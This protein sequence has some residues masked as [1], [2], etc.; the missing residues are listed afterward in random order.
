MS[1]DE[2][3]SQEGLKSPCERMVVH[4]YLLDEKHSMDAFV[5]NKAEAEMLGLIRHILAQLKLDVKV[6]SF[7]RKEGGL[8]DTFMLIVNSPALLVAASV[9][10]A[11]FLTSIINIIVSLVYSRDKALDKPTRELLELNIA[12]KRLSIE[13]KRLAIEKARTELLKANAD[14]AI[15]GNLLPLLE[16]DPKTITLISNFF[17]VLIS[18]QDVTAVGLGRKPRK[19]TAAE[20][21]VNRSDFARYVVHSDKLPTIVHHD[22]IVQIVAPVITKGGFHWRGVWQGESITFQMRDPAYRAIVER[23]Q[24]VFRSGDAIKCELNIERKVDALGDEVITG[25]AVTAVTAKIEGENV[26]MTAK[27]RQM[28]FDKT[29][30]P[31]N[32]TGF[33]FDAPDGENKI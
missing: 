22:A 2:Q 28:M 1:T 8:V 31:K 24:E 30:G 27:G 17:K 5:R 23:G 12:E 25:H 26:K 6:E 3:E 16:N 21:V 4:Y 13:E 14:P 7:A 29:H 20:R 33:D 32:Q 11:G 10:A 18:S 9:G 19:G 15:V